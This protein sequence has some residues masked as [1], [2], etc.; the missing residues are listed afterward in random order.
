MGRIIRVKN[1]YALK[2]KKVPCRGLQGTRCIKNLLNF[3]TK[4]DKSYGTIV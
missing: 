3:V 4:T 2:C 1:Y